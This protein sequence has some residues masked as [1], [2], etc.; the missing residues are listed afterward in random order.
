MS[1]DEG[2][3]FEATRPD[4]ASTIT[5]KI[6]QE[7][8]LLQRHVMMLKAVMDNQPVGIIK[9]AEITGFPQ[10]KVRYSL[11]I[12]ESEGLIEPS[13]QGAVTTAKVYD[14][15]ANLKDLLNSMANTVADLRKT[16]GQQ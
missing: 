9:L 15:L 1:L 14:F 3:E 11:R 7:I 13:P 5:G 8:E 12:L 16:L 2:S 6:E 4:Q 10:H